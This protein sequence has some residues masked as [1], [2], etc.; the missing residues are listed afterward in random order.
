MN[1]CHKRAYKWADDVLRLLPSVSF[2]LIASDVMC[3]WQCGSN[4]ISGRRTDNAMKS[5]FDK[6]CKWLD[7]PTELF[8]VSQLHAEM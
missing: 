6:L 2:D 4:H 5:I 3:H 8:T 7:E 1:K